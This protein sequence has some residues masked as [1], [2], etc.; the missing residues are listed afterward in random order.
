MNGKS[1]GY[2][3]K[4]GL[5]IAAYY[6]AN[7]V[8]QG[9][10]PKYYQLQGM[11]GT[12]MMMLLAAAPAVA[13]I[14]QPLWG[15]IGDRMRTRNQALTVMTVSATVL[16]LL[17][18]VN[19]SFAWLMLLTC[20]FAA[21]FT[22]VQ[23]MGDSIILE[24]LEKKRE[25]FGP[26]RLFGSFS[27]AINNLI[28]GQIFEDRYHIVP[29]V[30]AIFILLLL[31]STRV[32]PPTQGHQHGKTKVPLGDILRLPYMKQL[33]ALVIVLQLAMG[34]YYSYFVL[35]FTSLPGGTSGLAGLA[36]FISAT[37][38][39]PFLI[40]SDRLFKRFG[41]GKLMVVS[42]LLIT[43]RF[44]V[45][46]L[47]QNITLLLINQITHGGGF[48]VITVTMAK[49]ISLMVP[50]ELK[51]GGQMVLAVVGYGLARVFGVLCG[52]FIQQATGGPAG[53]F[54]A[55][56]VLCFVAFLLSAWYF[57]PRPPLNGERQA[58]DP[59]GVNS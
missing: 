51:A 16:I 1:K 33:M 11:D 21:F 58:L 56:G 23:P 26:I 53:G 29:W 42:A 20:L 22:P 19:S 48:I 18:L 27:F 4:Y 32:L 13:I 3:W 30:N 35:H 5:F 41:T 6:A 46:G 47:S 45:L 28:V 15:R 49:Y 14:A 54:L 31:L 34:Y 7:A 9:F 52:G 36:F 2:P 40:F 17:I 43:I 59:A 8:Y 38:E 55:M 10:L 24:N 50:D 25:P 39:T 44:L 12:R 37:S 57:L